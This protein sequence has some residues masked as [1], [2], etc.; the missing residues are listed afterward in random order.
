MD[1]EIWKDVVGFEGRY[2]V[3][4]MGRVKSLDFT[5]VVKKKFGIITVPKYGKI[6]KPKVDKGGYYSQSLSIDGKSYYKSIHRMVLTAFVPNPENKPEI[7][8]KDGNKSNNC[9]DNLEWCNRS[10]NNLHA[11]AMGLKVSIKGNKKYNA[12]LS[13]ESVLRIREMHEHGYT[14][15]EIR[16]RFNTKP[17]NIYAIIA[18][19]T[20][21]H[22]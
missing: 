13:D 4:N 1:E 5:S 8:H 11:Y 14:M 6:L 10:E 15:D 3:S 19:R 9:V 12:W 20:W 21:K 2:M 16:E 17:Q 22:I 18:R 7:N